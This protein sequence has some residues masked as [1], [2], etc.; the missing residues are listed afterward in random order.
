MLDES[1]ENLYHAGG[2]RITATRRPE[3]AFSVHLNLKK[4]DSFETRVAKTGHYIALEDSGDGP[5]HDGN[6]PQD[7]RLLQARVHLLCAP[8]DRGRRHRHHRRLDQG[9]I[10]V[11]FRRD[12]HPAHLCQP[13]EHHHPHHAPL[14]DQPGEDRSAAHPSGGRFR[15][16]FHILDRADPRDPDPERLFGSERPKRPSSISS[17]SRRTASSSM[18]G[19]GDSSTT[20]TNTASGSTGRLS[21]G[22]SDSDAITVQ[23]PD[24]E[25]DRGAR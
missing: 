13:G 2:A 12:R 9:E 22:P 4:H 11:L 19:S 15:P 7:I 5:P 17:T 20:R 14:R 8:E 6:G 24:E 18:T 23:K 10:P 16:E 25:P 21:A 3:R 1:R